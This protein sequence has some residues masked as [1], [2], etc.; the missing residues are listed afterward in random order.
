MY[1]GFLA[2]GGVH[3]LWFPGLWWCSFTAVSWLMVVFM[4]CGFLACG[5]VHVL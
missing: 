3:V 4:Y 1:C 2:C 5:G